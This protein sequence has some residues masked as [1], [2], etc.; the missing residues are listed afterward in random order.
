MLDLTPDG[1]ALVTRL[2]ADHRFSEAAVLA[3]L[4][5]MIR[6]HGGM[7]QFDHPEFGGAGQ[8][9]RGGMLMV[10]DPFDDAR[11][12][13]IAALCSELSQAV[14][15]RAGL[16]ADADALASGT[17]DWWPRDW[18]RP[19]SSGSQNGR[20]YAYFPESRRL[21][22]EE[23]GRVALYDTGDH[24]IG[25]FSQQQGGGDGIAFSSQ[26]GPV[27]LADLR[28][29]HDTADVEPCPG[30]EPPKPGP[31]PSRGDDPFAAIERL[32]DLHAR[33]VLDAA[34]FAAKKKE[35]LALI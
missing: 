25:G 30:T 8:W 21:A 16:V 24:R 20:R 12:A 6:G 2:A 35:L 26:H 32:A 3:L 31:A 1:R 28:P 27:A 33:G 5:A 15:S 14:A 18:G 17:P 34:E 4:A 7:A 22:I 9:M 13:R 29:L 11:K 19:A 10:G 23:G